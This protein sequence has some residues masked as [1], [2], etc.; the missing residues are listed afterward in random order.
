MSPRRRRSTGATRCMRRRA[1]GRSLR[2]IVLR[3]L[4]GRRSLPPA[5]SRAGWRFACDPAAVARHEGSRT[6]SRTPWKR[7][8]WIARNRWKTLFRNFDRRLLRRNALALLRADLAHARLARLARAVFSSPLTWRL[9]FSSPALARGLPPGAGPLAEWPER[10]VP[11]RRPPAATAASPGEPPDRRRRSRRSSSRGGTRTTSRNRSARSPRPRVAGPRRVCAFRSSPSETG[12]DR[13]APIASGRSGPGAVVVENPDNR[14]F[15]PAANQGAAAASGD[16]L[17]FLNP[18]TRAEGDPFTPLAAAS[19]RGPARWRSRPGSRRPAASPLRAAGRSASRGAF[20][21]EDQ[22]TFQLRRL[23]RLSSDA[24]RAASLGAPPPER[25]RAAA[26]A[27][28]GRG[29]EPS[30]SRRA[31]RR[32]RA[33]GAE[34]KRSARSAAS[35]SRSCP[36][37]F[38]DVD[39]CARLAA[40]GE[41]LYWPGSVFRHAGGVSSERLGY[42]RFLP[43]LYANALRYRAKHYPPGARAVYRGLLAAGMLLRLAALPFRPRASAA[44]GARP[45]APIAPCCGSRRGLRTRP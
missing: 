29:P 26:R 36:A 34:R 4:R 5:R 42:D 39:L 30:L 32:G 27:L 38:E 2:P 25:T 31:G 37:W 33:R 44:P 13:S 40:R 43:I 15:G 14:G 9:S 24:A 28:R 21:D 41:I 16:V 23:P 6:G 8:K 22:F 20:G 35:T 12:R 7:A 11:P 1:A 45:R 10:H 18:D 17:L 19:R 3:L